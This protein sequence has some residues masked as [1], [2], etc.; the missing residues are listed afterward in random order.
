MVNIVQPEFDFVGMMRVIIKID[1]PV[2]IIY[3]REENR[4][5]LAKCCDDFIIIIA[6]NKASIGEEFFIKKVIPTH[7]KGIIPPV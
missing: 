3:S 6:I 5:I 4:C 1:F 2:Y 7:G